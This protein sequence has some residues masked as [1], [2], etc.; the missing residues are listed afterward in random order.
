M[1]THDLAFKAMSMFLVELG[2]KI[3]ELTKNYKLWF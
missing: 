3:N 1:N 2:K